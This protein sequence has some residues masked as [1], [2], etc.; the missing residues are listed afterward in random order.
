M[1]GENEEEGFLRQLFGTGG[2]QYKKD[3]VQS[4]QT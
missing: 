1:T 2:A 3:A 4:L